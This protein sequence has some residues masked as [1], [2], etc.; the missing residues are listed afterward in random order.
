MLLSLGVVFA[1]VLVILG[2]TLRKHTQVTPSVNYKET[3]AEVAAQQLIPALKPRSLPRN[4]QVTSARFEPESY[5]STGDMRWYLGITL[6]DASYL[7]LW[8]STGPLQK[9][10]TAVANGGVCQGSIRFAGQQW[11]TCEGGRPFSRVLYRQDQGISTVIS[12]SSDWSAMKAFVSSL[13]P[14]SPS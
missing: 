4:A 8:Q 7:S 9:V 12:G 10:V 5:G 1:V 13:T 11:S 6:S 3:L 2:V 14:V